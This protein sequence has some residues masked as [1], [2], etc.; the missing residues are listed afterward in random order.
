MTS[1][2]RLKYISKKMFILW[3]PWYVSKIYVESICGYSKISHKNGFV[4]I[5][6]FRA[7][8]MKRCFLGAMHSL[9]CGSSLHVVYLSSMAYKSFGSFGMSTILRSQ[10]QVYYL[11]L[12]V[13]FSNNKTLYNPQPK[14]RNLVKISYKQLRNQISDNYL[15]TFLVTMLFFKVN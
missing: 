8:K 11:L 5:K 12:L 14:Y 3:R 9:P 10:E 7:D 13:I 15:T 6:S 1:L 2:R 4:L